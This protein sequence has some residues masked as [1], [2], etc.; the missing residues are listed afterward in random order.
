MK[1]ALT[2][3][4][5][6]DT[7][8]EAQPSLTAPVNASGH[9]QQLDRIFGFFSSC[10][11]SIV[12]DNAWVAGGGALVSPRLVHHRYPAFADRPN[13]QVVALSNGGAPGVIYELLVPP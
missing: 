10:S 8:V 13:V 11:I 6:V 4:K 2:D 12:S 9:I 5:K 1:D 7:E 3:E